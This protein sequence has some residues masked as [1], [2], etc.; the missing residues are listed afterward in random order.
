MKAFLRT[1]LTVSVLLLVFSCSNR[2][3]FLPMPGPSSPSHVHDYGDSPVSYRIS[4]TTIYGTYECVGC[5][6]TIEK[7]VYTN[8]AT[9]TDDN[10]DTLNWKDGNLVVVA[11]PDNAQDILDRI[12]NNSVVYFSEGS[13]GELTL[14]PSQYNLTSIHGYSGHSDS[15][16]EYTLDQIKDNT[17]TTI[18]RFDVELE[19]VTFIGNSGASFSKFRISSGYIYGSGYNAVLERDISGQQYSYESYMRLK[20]LSFR[21]MD[22]S[23]EGQAFS[24]GFSYKGDDSYIDGLTIDSCSFENTGMENGGQAIWIQSDIL[25]K[26]MNIT[27]NNCKFS[28][29]FQGVYIQNGDGITITNCISDNTTHNAFAVQNGG[30]SGGAADT[31]ADYFTGSIT[32]GNNTISNTSGKAGIRFGNGYN[33]TIL[34]EDNTI[35]NAAEAVADGSM[36][37]E[38]ENLDN[39]T[40]SFTGNTYN[41]VL[42]E[43]I[44]GNSADWDLII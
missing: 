35:S 20:S 38:S 22:F 44:Q 26:Y 11:T 42:L 16:T 13:Y 12:R 33:A 31:E 27:V 1:L 2:I 19:N 10:L 30:K 5:G 7:A 17:T 9:V 18:Y 43:D 40:Y 39:C 23:G 28:G 14:R 32:I 36:I 34:I 37:L 6:N 41:G 15:D 4:G 24:T 8:A 29:C 25:G 3:V 21:G